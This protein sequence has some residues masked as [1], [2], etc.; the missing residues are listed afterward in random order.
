M[1][2]SPFRK[3]AN[4]SATQEFSSILWNPKVHYRVH[5]SPDTR[6][7]PIQS[8]EPHPISPRSILNGEISKVDRNLFL[9]LHGHNTPCQQRNRPSF[10]CATSSWLLMLTAGSRDQLPRWRCSYSTAI[11]KQRLRKQGPLLGNVRNTHSRYNIRA[12][13]SGVLCA[14][15]AD[16]V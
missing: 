2:L 7:R 16:F 10:S 9:T 6:D 14:V 11:A 5:K 12:V 4:S 13:W 1:E 15:S 3:D 8:I